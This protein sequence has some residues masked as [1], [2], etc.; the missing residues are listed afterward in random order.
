MSKKTPPKFI[1][2]MSYETWKN[3]IEM[4]KIVTSISKKEQGIIVLLE[5]LEGNNRAE[6]A[7]SELT[8]AQ[9]NIDTGLDVLLEKLDKV[10]VSDTVDEAYSTYSRFIKFHKTSDMS[11]TEY[12]IEYEHLSH[13]MIE[14]KMTLPDTVLTFKLLD[15]AN[16][17]EDDRKLAL[18]LSS[19]LKLD[20]MKSA[21]KRIFTKLTQQTETNDNQNFKDEEAFFSKNTLYK[22]RNTRFSKPSKFPKSSTHNAK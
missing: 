19:D 5:S 8:A 11:M 21:L 13:K 12:I 6:K 14:H 16:L 18:T 1:Q 7:V 17:T 9:L 15:G 10:F 3:K 20:T 2:G 4:W 22:T